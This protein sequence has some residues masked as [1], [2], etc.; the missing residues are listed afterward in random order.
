MK[1]LIK[2][3]PL[4][5]NIYTEAPT[6]PVT[7]KSKIVVF[8][9]LHMG[10]GSKKDDFTHNSNLVLEALKSYYRK[11]YTLILNGDIEELQKFRITDIKK[12]W[13]QIY[14]VFNLF[15]ERGNLYKIVG[16]HDERLFLKMEGFNDYPL[17]N[18][19]KG[20]FQGNILF[21]FHGHQ[22]NQ[23][24]NKYNHILEFFLR[25]LVKP[26][27]LKNYSV[28][29]SS[30]RQFKVEKL[31][32]M[33]SVSRRIVSLIGHTHRPLFESL[34]KT[35]QNRYKIEHLCRHFHEFS[36]E[37]QE[38]AVL[39]IKELREELSQSDNRSKRYVLQSQLYS[40]DV[41]VP[42]LFNSGTSI[43][44]RGVTCLEIEGGKLNLS[45]WYDQSKKTKH[46]SSH[47][48]PQEQLENIDYCKSI[49][50][51]DQLAYIFTKINLL[52]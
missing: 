25:F 43:G 4:V 50:K 16:N 14:Q 10:D 7:T 3:E 51:S 45:H 42:C 23:R 31:G 18:G 2:V 15:Y 20:D 47:T 49:I 39:E 30:R 40:E 12:A 13:P 32:Y 44:K 27:G 52:T 1:A 34:S 33:Y 46:I 36:K 22:L 9:D 21:F 29:H 11:G 8:S 5:D 37:D 19:I 24:Y 6:L 26:L 35:D 48:Y 38:T 17:Y 28:A 41:V